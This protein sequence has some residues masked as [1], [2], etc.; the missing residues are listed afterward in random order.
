MANTMAH[1]LYVDGHAGSLR[2]S[3]EFKTELLRRNVYVPAP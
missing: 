2:Y 1:F 3:S